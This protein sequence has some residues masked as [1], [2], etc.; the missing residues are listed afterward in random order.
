M[1]FQPNNPFEEKFRQFLQEPETQDAIRKDQEKEIKIARKIEEFE[2]LHE[3]TGQ[4][5]QLAV[6]LQDLDA[7]CQRLIYPILRLKFIQHILFAALKETRT[8]GTSFVH[9]VRRQSLLDMFARVRDELNN[10]PENAKRIE[11]EWFHSMACNLEHEAK[12][13]PKKERQV[14]P[15]TQMLPIIQSGVQLRVNGNHKFK[16]QDYQS[17]LEMYMQGCVGF[18]MYCAT[19]D[20]DQKLL[21]EVHVAIRKNTAGAALKTRDYTICIH[22]CDKVLE[23][24]P[25]DTKSLYRRALANW[26][27]GEVEKACADLEAILRTR[28]NDYNEVAESATAK[29]AARKLLRQIE[30]SEERAEVVEQ[31]MAKALAIEIPKLADRIS[32]GGGLAPEN[33]AATDGGSS[34]SSSSS[35]SGGGG[36]GATGSDGED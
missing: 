11:N 22:S 2:S 21:D 12:K 14:L 8:S 1:S 9:A 35:S 19:N 26:R 16:A 10:D 6:A 31:K 17:A 30:E 29:K 23:M 33:H 36:G 27:L 7:E 20:Q 4:R 28:V 32:I 13:K 24:A 34:S 5:E 18:E 3:L 25:G 15:A